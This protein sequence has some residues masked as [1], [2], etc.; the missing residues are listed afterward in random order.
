MPLHVYSNTEYTRFS[1]GAEDPDFTHETE[2]A[3]MHVHEAE[4]AKRHVPR[5]DAANVHLCVCV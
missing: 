4:E 2:G 3:K 5:D 1:K